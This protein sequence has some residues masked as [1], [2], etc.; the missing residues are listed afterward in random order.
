MANSDFL[1]GI[2]T[3]LN[4][5]GLK[6]G[7]PP[8]G[9][10]VTLLGITSNTGV[11]KNTPMTIANVEKAINSL[12]FSG[13]P[14]TVNA[15]PGELSLAVEEA[16][17]AGAQHIEVCVIGHYSG[18]LLSGYI[19]PSGNHSGR[20]SDLSGGHDVLM[21]RDLDVVMP[22]GCYIDDRS[23]TG[24]KNFGSQLADFCFQA[25]T[26]QNSCLG[27][28]PVQPP[29]MWA[30]NQRS[31]AFSGTSVLT[32]V[33]TLD[34]GGS[35]SA[36]TTNA[37][38]WKSIRFADPSTDLVNMWFR[39]H[40]G[41]KGELSAVGVGTSQAV[42]YPTEYFDKISGSY[43]TAGGKFSAAAT[44]IEVASSYF[45]S[46]QVVDRDG[47]LATDA[48]GNK[49]DGGMYVSCPQMMVKTSSTQVGTL[50][51]K[52]GGAIS[53]SSYVTDGAASY[54]GLIN[55]LA[56]HSATTNKFV[57]G[58][59]PHKDLSRVQANAITGMRNVTMY[60][61][62][63]G[64][65]VTKDV[66]SAH[67][68]N[69]YTRSDYVLLTTLRITEA[70]VDGIRAIAENY[71]GEANNA[72]RINALDNE[73]NGFLL[74]MKGSALNGFDFVISSTPEERVLGVLNIDLTIVPAFEITDINLTVSLAKEI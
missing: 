54:A 16:V 37:N 52:L 59:F 45:T 19:N 39:Y 13:Q 71:L 40:T 73:I 1:P 24:H 18:N 36:G 21:T 33:K 29:I 10:K 4:D 42:V 68:V 64:Y 2:N 41:N 32:E 20:A 53:N 23:A 8:T 72:A 35:L 44:S 14:G 62:S 11:P 61:R 28:I 63:K 26:D 31:G 34:G 3:I 22:V 27:V 57:G 38:M 47:T 60:R 70:A 74:G 66:T 15:Y 67:N 5:A 43:N 55:S 69:K 25:T 58:L 12:Y 50:T 49:I 30:M 7:S 48:K 65:V 6:I 56:P 51:K 46:W 17:S 9:P